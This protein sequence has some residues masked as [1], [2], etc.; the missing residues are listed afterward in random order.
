MLPSLTLQADGKVD[1]IMLEHKLDAIICVAG[2][3][4]GGNTA[5][6]GNGYICGHAS[7]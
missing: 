3:W 5:S 4:A 7:L 6:A 1:D 2:G